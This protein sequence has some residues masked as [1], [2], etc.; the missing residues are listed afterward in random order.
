[1]MILKRSKPETSK[2]SSAPTKQKQVPKQRDT[3]RASRRL[4][5]L[6]TFGGAD[7]NQRQAETVRPTLLGQFGQ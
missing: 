4:L 2:A 6:T 5:D 7:R 3:L 1:M